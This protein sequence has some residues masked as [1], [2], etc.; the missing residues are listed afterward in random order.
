MNRVIRRSLAL[1]T[2]SLT[3]L[4]LVACG[5]SGDDS[6]TPAVDTGDFAIDQ[7]IDTG[8]AEAALLAMDDQA[9]TLPD[10]AQS[11]YDRLKTDLEHAKNVTGN[12]AETAWSKVGDDVTDVDTKIDAAGDSVDNA[13]KDAWSHV[14]DEFDK[15]TSHA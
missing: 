4:A 5:S 3:P 15:I 1:A 6:A 12:D 8:A 7:S 13:T 9:L 11:S 10:D 2:V 14:K